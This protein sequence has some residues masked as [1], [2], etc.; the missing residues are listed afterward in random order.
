[1]KENRNVHVKKCDAFFK[2]QQKQGLALGFGDIRLRTGYS[3]VSPIEANLNSKFSRN[4]NL[5]IPIVSSPMDTVTEAKM[6]IAMA[7]IG[8]L[9]II[10]KGLSPEEQAS[11]VGKVKHH[12]SAFVIDPICVK[13]SDKVADILRMKIK[14][15]YGFSSFP[16]V[17]SDKR[18]I[19]I[20]TGNDFE[21]C[22][23]PKNSTKFISPNSIVI[24]SSLD[25]KTPSPPISNLKSM[26]L[27]FSSLQASR[28]V[29]T[30]LTG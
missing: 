5:K 18:I 21:F 27:L 15:D 6:A 17:D 26:P 30:P 7:K 3:E 10:H 13:P 19:G 8:G 12:L 25:R 24:C 16:V 11:A 9:G 20:V 28:I 2:K 22:N 1:M 29:S 23:F 14:K 4:V